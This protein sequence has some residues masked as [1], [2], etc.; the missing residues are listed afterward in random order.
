MEERKQAV[1][2][3]RVSSKEQEKEG[4]SIPAQLKLL[5]DYARE[6]ELRV[7]KE[8]IDVETAK[9][10]GRSQFGGMIKFLQIQEDVRIVLV[11]KTDRLYRNF[12]DYVTLEDLDLIVHLVKENEVLSK[13][14]RSHT[15]FI[16]G[17]K[18]LMAKNYIDN[19]SEETKKGMREKAEQG[20]Y[21]SFA[22]LGY[23]NNRE[24]KRIEMDPEVAPLI[25]KLF[26]WYATGNYSLLQVR[27]MARRLMESEG[28]AFQYAKQLT[29]STVEHILKNPIY[30]GNFLWN[31]KLYHGSHPPIVSHALWE[32][33]QEAFRKSNHPKHTKREFPFIGMLMC[34]FCGCAITAEIKKGK[35]IYYHCTGNH[36]PC[37]RPAARQ[38]TL[39]EKLGE[40]IKGIT[41]DEN[42]LDWLIQALQESHH[43]EKAYHDRMIAS[44]QA[45]SDKLQHRID[46]AYTDKLDG[47][48]PEDLFLRKMNEWR[49]EQSKI[50]KQ[51][52]AHQTANHNYLEEGIRVLELANKAYSLYLRQPP[53]EKA[54]LLKIVQSNCVWDGVSACPEYRKPFDI[55]AEGLSSANWLPVLHDLQTIAVSFSLVA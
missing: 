44:L 27:H 13:D 33:T 5:H 35:Y 42:L 10:A 25:R 34:A 8:F 54:R 1:V 46:Q 4:F 53:H 16:H 15:K 51:I 37:P 29:K 12:K 50:L 9:A 3:A 47:K 7:I 31:A 30:Y 14:S 28:L 36:G 26:E 49:E 18:V 23:Q 48:I 20:H 45:Q 55:L 21:P 52:R 6:Q 22:P 32:Q 39:E 17:I 43:D 41:I 38:E 40:V 19:L 24:T 2:Y 11:E